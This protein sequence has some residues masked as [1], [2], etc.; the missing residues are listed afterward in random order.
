MVLLLL[1]LPL[2]LRDFDRPLRL[3]LEG[4]NDL[5]LDEPRE[6]EEDMSILP[7]IDA[8]DLGGRRFGA[9]VFLL[10][11]CID[12]DDDRTVFEFIGASFDESG[13]RRRPEYEPVFD[14]I[15]VIL[16]EF[17]VALLAWLFV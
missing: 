15:I 6:E 7:L 16:V 1:L 12:G 17:I 11:E 4:V 3:R 2:R 14:V 13:T 5:R 9:I 8:G 10:E